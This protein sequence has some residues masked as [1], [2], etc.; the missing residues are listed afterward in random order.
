M[1]VTIFIMMIEDLQ[2]VVYD[3]ADYLEMEMSVESENASGT[4]DE[5]GPQGRTVTLFGSSLDIETTALTSEDVMGATFNVDLVH[6]VGK[7]VGN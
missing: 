5:N 6:E 4:R 1:Q 3:P 2:Y 7:V